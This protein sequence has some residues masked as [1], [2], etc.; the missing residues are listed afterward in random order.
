MAR[1]HQPKATAMVDTVESLFLHL[2]G[3]FPLY[4]C[5]TAQRR[6]S[7]DLISS[8]RE[9]FS[10]SAVWV[11]AQV[12]TILCCLYPRRGFSVAVCQCGS[13]D[14]SM[15][16]RRLPLLGLRGLAIL[17]SAASFQIRGYPAQEIRDMWRNDQ[18][19]TSVDVCSTESTVGNCCMVL[20]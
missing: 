18:F 16:G 10:A 6:H 3:D 4:R 19:C 13:V 20:W 5:T 17:G 8:Y 1:A 12:L 11:L 15:N 14:L 2:F 9:A 7:F